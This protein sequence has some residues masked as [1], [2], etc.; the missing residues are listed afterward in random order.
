MPLVFGIGG[1]L[2]SIVA[3]LLAIWVIYDVWK[4]NKRLNKEEKILW[5]VF[6]V[7]FSII[8]A[9]VYYIVKKK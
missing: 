3:I 4:K 9:I 8:T 2:I 6:A 7:I 1:T 5:T